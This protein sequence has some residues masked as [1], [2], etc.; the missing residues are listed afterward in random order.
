MNLTDAIVRKLPAPASGNKITYDDVVKGFGVRITAA[1]AK[2]F[3]L[4][5]RA[6][7]VE[8]RFTI[9]SF[10]DWPTS[11]AREEAKRLK[12]EVDRGGD[13]A[14]NR[15]E[16]RA[17]PTVADLIERYRAEHATRKRER[18]RL[19]DESL[20]RQWIAPELGNRK[21]ADVR[22][23]DIERVHRKITDRGTPV[24]ANRFL[25]LLSK[26]FTLAVRWEMRGDNPVA[27]VERNPEEPR[28]R[29]LTGDEMQRLAAALSAL[30]SQQAANAIRLLLLT[31]ARRMEV[32]S[33]PWSQFDLKA[34]VWTKPSSHTKQK[35]MHRVP[36]SVPARTLL[37][38][39]RATAGRSAYLF[40]GRDDGHLG[41]VKKSWHTVCEAAKLDGVHIHDLRHSFAATLA[42]A[43]QS[44][45]VIGALLGHVQ[46]QTTARYAHLID[47]ALRA[48]TE[49]AGAVITGG[50][51]R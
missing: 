26:M 31:G 35:K 27:G 45:P 51:K 1:G 8:R 14:L 46:V 33:A 49:T 23:A 21:V 44:L 30:R 4:N 15:R 40:P 36:L 11:A 7:G 39:M 17:A 12:R 6:H 41:D 28:H 47:D 38:E 34:G 19:E 16:A 10:P 37:A 43:G 18:S 13:P 9:G 42:S 32:L 29:Y 24:R 50:E 5:Y 48:A 3:V 20:I 25:I 22:R 2:S